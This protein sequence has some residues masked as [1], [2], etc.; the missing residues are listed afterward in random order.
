MSIGDTVKLQVRLPRDL[1]EQLQMLSEE[2]QRSLNGQIVYLLRRAVEQS[3][4][5]R[6]V[7]IA[8]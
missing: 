4:A 8:A 6:Q 2:E 5:E 7:K 1:H 3:A